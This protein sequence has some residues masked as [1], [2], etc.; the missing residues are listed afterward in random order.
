MTI[1]NSWMGR[2]GLLILLSGLLHLVAIFTGGGAVG[3]ATLLVI[4]I[5]YSLFAYG[6]QQERRWLAYV[7]YVVML[8][9]AIAAYLSTT[10]G[11]VFALIA[12]TDAAAAIMLFIALWG[13][14][15]TA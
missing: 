15:R 2:A 3:T 11:V 4:A 9:G 12:L 8:L 6:L 13:S 7:C 5:V 14:P 1:S 10:N